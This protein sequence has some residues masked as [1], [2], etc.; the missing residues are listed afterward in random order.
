MGSFGLKKQQGS[1]RQDQ[2]VGSRFLQRLLS[3]TSRLGKR[4]GSD[5]CLATA[6]ALVSDHRINVNQKPECG[7]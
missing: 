6:G 2:A 5:A 7:R 3:A 4:L 1:C